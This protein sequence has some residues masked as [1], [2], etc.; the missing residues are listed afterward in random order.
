[1]LCV[2]MFTGRVKSFVFVYFFFVLGCDSYVGFATFLCVFLFVLRVGC[3]LLPCADPYFFLSEG[4]QLSQAGHLWSASET[5]FKWR[6]AGVPM[7]AQH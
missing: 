1:M 2:L 6:F 3:D 5:P 4:V 7:M